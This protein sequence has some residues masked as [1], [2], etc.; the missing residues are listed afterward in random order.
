MMR[1]MDTLTSLSKLMESGAYK[2]LTTLTLHII[3]PPAN[4]F[5]ALE[6]MRSL[7]KLHITN[8]VNVVDRDSVPR[9]CSKESIAMGIALQKFLESAAL[10]EF[11]IWGAG[12][13]S[14]LPWLVRAL[15][16]MTELASLTYN[17]YSEPVTEHTTSS[18]RALLADQLSTLLMELPRCP[19]LTALYIDNQY[20]T[21]LF[22]V[23][24]G[25]VHT[26][27]RVR[28]LPSYIRWPVHLTTQ[29]RLPPRLCMLP[30]P[31][32]RE[33][34]IPE[35]PL[36]AGVPESAQALP[37]LE[38]FS[39]T[40]DDSRLWNHMEASMILNPVV[41]PGIL[42]SAFAETLDQMQGLRSIVLPQLVLPEDWREK[43]YRQFCTVAITDTLS[44]LT[45]LA[46]LQLSVWDRRVVNT[47]YRLRWIIAIPD[48]CRQ[49]RSI[50][51]THACADGKLLE[52]YPDEYAEFLDRVRGCG[53]RN[54]ECNITIHGDVHQ[55]LQRMYAKHNYT[56]QLPSTLTI[57]P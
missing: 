17:H 10:R 19:T 37:T 29:Q 56:Q 41:E 47:L 32:L 12:I 2:H 45:N 16:H 43:M 31:N 40:S 54:P 14:T 36:F 52:I 22:G 33:L 18:E 13:F 9:E 24:N 3:I 1:R 42:S 35:M 25:P 8:T 49:L 21:T 50:I 23:K 28:H 26:P 51:V 39:I 48:A 4:L 7:R 55:A 5:K 20:N 53:Q 30:H 27:I 38:R 57:L 15:P 11:E 46:S 44:K 34:H 6:K